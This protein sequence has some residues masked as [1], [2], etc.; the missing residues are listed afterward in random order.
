[1]SAADILKVK[2]LDIVDKNG[3]VVLLR[4]VGRKFLLFLLH[5]LQ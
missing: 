1:M 2:G 5:V 3:R 4:G